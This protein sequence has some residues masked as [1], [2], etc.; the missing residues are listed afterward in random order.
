MVKLKD[1]TIQSL[2]NFSY[3]GLMPLNNLKKI[4]PTLFWF[5]LQEQ[6]TDDLVIKVL[7]I[8]LK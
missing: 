7:K 1:P 4:K 5:Q 3:F 2:N 8:P 6:D